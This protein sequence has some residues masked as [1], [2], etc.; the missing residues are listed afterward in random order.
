MRGCHID[1]VLISILL[2]SCMLTK[3]ILPLILVTFHFLKKIIQIYSLSFKNIEFFV[4]D[5]L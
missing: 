2:F 5:M 3:Y 4:Y 1:H